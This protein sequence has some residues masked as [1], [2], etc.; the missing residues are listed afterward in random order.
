MQYRLPLA[1]AALALAA[2]LIALAVA[3][4]FTNSLREDLA[5]LRSDFLALERELKTVAELASKP[6][7]Q[8]PVRHARLF[9]IVRDGDAYILTDA[10]RRRVLLVPRDVPQ[11]EVAYY[12]NKYAPSVIV[13]YPVE[14]AVYM[15]STHV[16]L[17]YRLYAEAGRPGVLRSIAGIMWG[18]SYEWHLPGIAEMIENGTIADVGPA[19]SPDYE[20]IL[21][22]RPDVI[23]VYFYPGPYGTESVIARLEQLKLP[24]AVINEFQEESPLGRFEWIKFIAAFYNLTDLASAVLDRVE[25]E[26]ESVV[27]RVAD[28]DRPRVA[29]FSIHSGVLYPARAQAIELIRLAGGRYAYANYS[30]VDL[31]VVMRHKSDV[32]VL[33]WSGYG[34][35]RVEDILKVEPRLAELRPVALGR[36]YAF[37]PA[38]WQLSHAYPE[39]LLRELAAILHPEVIPPVNLTLFVQLR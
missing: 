12:A 17:A 32:D 34:V 28:L 31:E 7:A 27:A 23:F 6:V 38:F 33:V 4:L 29:W 15:S 25:R 10:M 3:V 26:W 19:Q 30:R 1:V 5:H 11:Y 14:R 22:L 21:Q 16:A 18:K 35:S 24:Y 8:I 20:K 39:R 2:S 37:S 36:V 9:S 13:R